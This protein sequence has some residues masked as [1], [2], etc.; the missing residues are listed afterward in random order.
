MGVNPSMIYI[1]SI[2]PHLYLVLAWVV[3]D[4]SRISTRLVGTSVGIL[5][6]AKKS[7]R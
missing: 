2:T 6:A 1:D 5:T 3:V 7:F 4:A